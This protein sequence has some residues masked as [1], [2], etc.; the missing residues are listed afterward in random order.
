MKPVF[1]LENTRESD[2][3]ARCANTKNH[4]NNLT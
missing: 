3:Y 4:L 2:I 1:N